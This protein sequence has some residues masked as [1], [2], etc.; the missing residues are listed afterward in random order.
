MISLGTITASNLVILG[1]YVTLDTITSNT[2][3]MVITNDGTGPALIVTQTGPQPIADFY[4]DGGELAMR[5]ADGGNVGIGTKFPLQKLHVNGAVQ[6]H[7]QFLGQAS[8][9]VTTPS[10]SWATDTNTG[11]F[12]PVVDQ[13]GIVTAAAERV[14][15]IANG[16]VGIGTTQPLQA[17]HVQGAVQAHTQFLG[18]A[19]DIVSAPSFSWATDTNTGLYLPATDSI[20]VVTNGVERLRVDVN[21]NVGI[22]IA[23]PIVKFHIENTVIAPPLYAQWALSGGGDVTWSAGFVKWSIRL[24][25]LPV[26]RTYGTSGYIDINCPLSGTIPAYS[27]ASGVS[28]V[29]CTSNGIPLSPWQSLYYVVSYGQTSTSI[30]SQFVVVSHGN[31]SFKL[32]SNWLLLAIRNGDDGCLKWMGSH[33]YIPNN[34]TKIRNGLII[35]SSPQAIQDAGFTGDGYFMIQGPGQTKPI[36]ML[37]RCNYIDSKPWVL[38]FASTY[39]SPFTTNLVGN[40]IPWKGIAV[41]RNDTAFQQTAYFTSNQ[42]FNQRNIQVTSTSGTRAGFYVYIGYAGGMGIYSTTQSV[43]SWSTT[44]GAV[45]AGWDGTNCG[46][47][48]N[49]LIWG[50]GDGSTAYVNRGGAFEVLLWWD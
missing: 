6:A 20:G 23:N 42:L 1:D 29:T 18:Q 14:R 36:E 49:G 39:A 32:T 12:L 2:E 38:G 13:I 47:W 10:F 41:Q 7:T 19:S 48:P 50:T 15:V 16:N 46:S 9:S 35:Y 40:N 8:D 31:T 44:N 45:G 43:C 33:A 4:D 26:D 22:G 17:L 30:Q 21:G 37:V 25:A 27:E 11:L 5:I 34:S 28:T 3:Q 24:I